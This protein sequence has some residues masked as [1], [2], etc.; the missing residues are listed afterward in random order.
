MG[1]KVNYKYSDLN[2]KGTKLLR[3]ADFA[4]QAIRTALFTQEGER[5]FKPN[6]GSRLEEYL[7]HTMDDWTA[8]GIKSEII[9]IIGQV[10]ELAVLLKTDVIP[11]YTNNCYIVK[12]E[13]EVDGVLT[14]DTI[15]IKNKAV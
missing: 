6:F 4:R 1:D 11:D 8:S 10:S 15:T 7:W 3:N 14:E 12:L 2:I 9:R 5:L 13:L